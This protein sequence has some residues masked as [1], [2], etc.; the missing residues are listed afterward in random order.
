MP[1]PVQYGQSEIHHKRLFISE[2]Q[3]RVIRDT[4]FHQKITICKKISC[5]TYGIQGLMSKCITLQ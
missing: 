4:K 5:I 2:Y 3:E 1:T